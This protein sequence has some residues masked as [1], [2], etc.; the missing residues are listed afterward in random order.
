MG[1][2]YEG[3]VNPEKV[4]YVAEKLYNMGCYEISLGDTIG[5]G[6]PEKT[7][8]LF[9][10]IKNIPKENLAAHFHDTYDKAIENLLAAL[11]VNYYSNH[12]PMLFIGKYRNYRFLCCWIRRMPLC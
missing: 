2:P 8:K 7:H 4:N 12:I 1:C 10:A 9:Q 3:D 11:E 5:V 6:T